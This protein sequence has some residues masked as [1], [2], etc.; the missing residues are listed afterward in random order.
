[1]HLFSLYSQAVPTQE[2]TP[3]VTAPLP[4]AGTLLS[5]MISSVQDV[6]QAEIDML[7]GPSESVQYSQ[8]NICELFII[9]IPI[10]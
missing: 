8:V 6:V 2:D 7:K 1:M 9:Q 3:A 5:N 4:S 10:F